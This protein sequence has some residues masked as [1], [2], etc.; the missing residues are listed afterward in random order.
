MI[1]TRRQ[2]P[3]LKELR[4]LRDKPN[5]TLLFLEGPKLVEEA[6]KA[7]IPLKTLIVSSTYKE[8]TDLLARA[9]GRA[10]SIFEVSES[11]FASVSDLVEPQGLLAVGERP[12]WSW[13]HLKGKK[14]APIIIVDGLQNPGN[15]AAVLRTAEAAGAAGVITT[16]T[17]ARLNSPKALRGAMGSALRVPHLEHQEP[18]V[19]RD[20]LTNA[21]YTIYA[22][23]QAGSPSLLYTKV[24]W[25]RPCAIILGQEGSGVSD[26][27]QATTISIPM[28]GSVESLNV[29]AAAAILLYESYRQR[30]LS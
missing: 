5:D 22:A 4:E 26:A 8:S 1:I 25:N 19:I 18:G 10:K 6:I 24:D 7:S 16:P 13:D 20:H 29:A 21:G 9:R 23:D 14:P 30:R 28:E 15:V 12:R 2:H 3:L 27:W 11:I 17:T